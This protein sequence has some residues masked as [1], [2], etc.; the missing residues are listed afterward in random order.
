MEVR[1]PGEVYLVGGQDY[2]AI[3]LDW[4]AN[5]CNVYL[6][7][8]GDT[9]VMVD[10]GCGESLSA[11]L[12]NVHRM[13]LNV[14]DISHLLLTHE[15]LP[16]AGAADAL[17]KM[18]VEVLAGATAAQAVMAG[19]D[20]TA[21]YHYHKE[22]P[23][24]E[25]VRG[26]SDGECLT[27]GDCEFRTM[28]LPGHSPGSVAYWMPCEG[29]TILF[30]GDIVRSPQLE[31]F[32]NRLDY[33]AEQYL[34]SLRKLLEQPP[35]ILYPGHGIFCLSRG[36]V[37]VEEEIKKLLSTARQSPEPEGADGG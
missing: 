19:D 30:C 12:E 20:R 35:D 6:V 1:L 27:V 10:C 9:L 2:Q 14:K 4:P 17:G 25:K 13:E 5:D 37:W 23:A 33:D 18:G 36:R 15:H 32:R 21:A 26:L 16:H 29:Q 34:V 22:F 7:N 3:Y 28:S 24:A 31:G 8:T 11:I